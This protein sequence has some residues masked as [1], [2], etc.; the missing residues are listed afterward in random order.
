MSSRITEQDP[1]IYI[2][3]SLYDHEIWTSEPFTRGQAWVDLLLIAS[4]KDGNSIRIR[5]ILVKYD[6]GQ[7]VAGERFLAERWRWSRGKVRRFLA[8]LEQDHMIVPQK[9]NVTTV[10]TVVNYNT[11]Q[12]KRTTKRTAN[13]PQT[14]LNKELKG[15]NK[16]PIPPA[17]EEVHAY[18]IERGVMGD[19]HT[20]EF[21]DHHIARDWVLSNGRKMKDWKAAVRTWVSNINKFAPRKGGNQ[22]GQVSTSTNQEIARTLLRKKMQQAGNVGT[23]L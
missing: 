2:D 18:F 23:N 14:D 21:M 6:R 17:R 13:G 1:Y 22:N 8:E 3:R 11:R 20:D 19:P 10:Y 9:T 15:I 7:F 5:G 4:H 12:T 16:L